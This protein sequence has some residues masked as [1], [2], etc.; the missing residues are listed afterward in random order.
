MKECKG[1]LDGEIFV[2]VSKITLSFF[3]LNY[4]GFQIA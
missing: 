1:D 3:S 4:S 2:S